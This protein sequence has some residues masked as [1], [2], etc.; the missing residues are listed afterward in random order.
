MG[1]ACCIIQKH[2]LF[3]RYK[4]AEWARTSTKDAV[5]LQALHVGGGTEACKLPAHQ[6]WWRCTVTLEEKQAL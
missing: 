6:G 1:L 5:N 4:T 3:L 2:Q